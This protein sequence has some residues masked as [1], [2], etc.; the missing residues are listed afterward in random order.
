MCEELRPVGTIYEQTFPPRLGE[1]TEDGGYETIVTW[2]VVAH[3]NCL[4][5]D[6][7]T[8]VTREEIRWVARRRG[9]HWLELP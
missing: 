2:A 6:G 3:R 8:S 1:N 5:W 7:V 9:R 4:D